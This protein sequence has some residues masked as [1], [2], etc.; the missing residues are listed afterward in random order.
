[1]PTGAKCRSAILGGGL[2]DIDP[3]STDQNIQVKVVR[4]EP[5]ALAVNVVNVG[6]GGDNTNS[7]DIQ[8]ASH[9][10]FDLCH[11]LMSTAAN[12]ECWTCTSCDNSA[13]CK[14]CEEQGLHTEHVDQI[15]EFVIHTIHIL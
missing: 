9:Y 3:Q 6:N 15:H 14:Q 7:E 11:T 5:V 10:P 8:D 4:V 1:M 13:I 2:K 12:T